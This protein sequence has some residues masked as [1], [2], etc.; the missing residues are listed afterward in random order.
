LDVTQ[1][2]LGVADIAELRTALPKCA[3]IW[4]GGLVVPG[5]AGEVK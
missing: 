3:I 5:L 2:G 1:T 4:D